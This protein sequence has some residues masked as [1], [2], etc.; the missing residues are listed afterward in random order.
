MNAL[1]RLPLTPAELLLLVL[2]G[3]FIGAYAPW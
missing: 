1:N 3:I 2:F